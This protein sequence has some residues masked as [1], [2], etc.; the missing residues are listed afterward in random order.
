MTMH[1]IWPNMSTVRDRKVIGALGRGRAG[2][3]RGFGGGRTTS[4]RTVAVHQVAGIYAM[5]FRC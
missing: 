5:S 1:G 3:G 4:E 2:A